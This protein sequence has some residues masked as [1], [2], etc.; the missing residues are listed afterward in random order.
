MDDLVIKKFLLVVG[1]DVAGDIVVPAILKY[2]PLQDA[3]SDKVTI[4][5]V[6]ID[7]EVYM[8]WVYDGEKFYDPERNV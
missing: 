8:G 5:Q 1:E 4:M 6:P 3:L 2:K 7:E